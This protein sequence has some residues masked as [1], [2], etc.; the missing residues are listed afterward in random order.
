MR[1]TRNS[2]L[3]PVA[4]FI[5]TLIFLGLSGCGSEPVK[6]PEP[7]QPPPVAE[8]PEPVAQPSGN[9]TLPP[10]AFQAQFQ[11]ADQ[12][13]GQ[14]KW[15]Q[16][17]EVIAA[18][19]EAQA[20]ASDRVYLGYLQARI[21]FIRGRQAQALKLLEQIDQP[22]INGAQRY[23]ILN[24]RR[25]ILELSGDNLES[26]RLGDQALLLAPAAD[27]P[28]LKRSIWH[29]LQKVGT[30][31]LQQAATATT[32]PRWQNWLE[33]AL[34][35]RAALPVQRQSLSLW[36]QNNPQ[37]PAATPLP[38]GLAY[39]LNPPVPGQRVALI[40]PLSGRLGAAG[41]AV[42]DGYLAG[43]YAYLESGGQK[44]DI[45]VLDQDKYGSAIAAYDAAVAQRASIVVGPLSK[46]AVAELGNREQR[47]IP[48]LALNRIDDTETLPPGSSALVQFALSPEDEARNIADIAFGQGARNALI[49]RPQDDR[50]SKVAQAL[51]TRWQQ[52]GGT[53]VNSV[54]YTSRDDYSNSVKAALGIPESEQRAQALRELLATN[55]E[56][57]SR[58]RQ[59]I[60]AVFL[61]SNSGAEARLLKPLLAFHYAASIPVY[62]VSSI[63]SGVPDP[64]DRDLDGINFVEIPWLVGANPELKSAVSA[65]KN[66]AD[67]YARLNAL[68][69]DAF[70]VQSQFAQLQA[71]A[72]ALLRGN[73]GLLSMDPQLH[74]QRELVLTTFDEG[75]IKAK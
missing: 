72:D 53:I 38:G 63:Y 25:H 11:Q 2:H 46:E 58:R 57:S 66:G 6:E 75:D 21:D 41:R 22:G 44:F 12:L 42:R 70:L 30:E 23:R 68:G 15:M 27:A 47:P 7:E 39:L 56:T 52:L 10:S 67:G 64:R 43:Y 32:D 74:I 5:L 3:R 19:P 20:T 55:I 4:Q 18:I 59:D 61:L 34:L 69:A 37:H 48:V 51:I 8:K 28:A 35:S 50:G 33:L 45:L 65:G 1:Q 73:T 16:A 17:S 13:L 36:L 9:T 40:L 14:Q 24:F 31:Q 62:A 54:T 60:D 49:L 71:G 26:A 29:D